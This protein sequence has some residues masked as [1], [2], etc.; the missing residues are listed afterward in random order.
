MSLA[1]PFPL[2]SSRAAAQG[3]SGTDSDSSVSISIA[4]SGSAH[5]RCPQTQGTRCVSSEAQA[6]LQYCSWISTLHRQGGCAH[7]TTSFGAIVE[8]R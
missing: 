1:E 7:F 4:C 5:S 3:T 6:A 2:Q 8:L